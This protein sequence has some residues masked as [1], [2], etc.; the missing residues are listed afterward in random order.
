MNRYLTAFP[1]LIALAATPAAGADM[2]GSVGQDES[3]WTSQAWPDF[4]GRAKVL[5]GDALWFPEQGRRVRL[6][7]IDACALPQWA[8]DP[9]PRAG[10]RE[11]A[12][13]PCG[14]LARAWL[15]RLIGSTVVSCRS[16]FRDPATGY[17]A[18]CSVHGRDLSLA[19]LRVGWAKTGR[20]GLT[21]PQYSAAER[22]ARS[23]R[24][25]IWG[26]YVLDMDEWRS[27]SVDRTLSRRPVADWNLLADRRMELTPP[28]V[29]WRNRPSRTDR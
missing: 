6:A 2:I 22:Y 5:D 8:F 20:S 16:V 4:R 18:T 12:P 7:G 17:V 11:P 14:P 21:N 24:Y 9:A 1:L 10:V 19:M 25:G 29:D 15:K 23:A 26:T 3:L 27:E 13:V 28:F